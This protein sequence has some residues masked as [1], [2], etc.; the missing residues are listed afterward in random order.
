M[1]NS[2]MCLEDVI[3]HNNFK[4]LT[5]KNISYFS[6][7]RI[8]IGIM[9]DSFFSLLIPYTQMFS[10]TPGSI[11]LLSN[12]YNFG[13]LT[14][15]I[16]INVP[17]IVLSK[18]AIVYVCCFIIVIV[19]VIQALIENYYVF[20]LCRFILGNIETIIYIFGNDIYIE[21]LP[22]KNRG[23]LMAL[24]NVCMQI[25]PLII[26]FLVYFITPTFDH[27]YIK[28][29]L[30]IASVI[31]LILGILYFL[32]IT[33]GI[34]DSILN[35][36]SSKAVEILKNNNVSKDKIDAYITQVKDLQGKSGITENKSSLLDLFKNLKYRKLILATMGIKFFS[37]FLSRGLSAGIPFV[38]KKYS[39]K[40]NTVND[41]GNNALV[42]SM[43]WG[44]LISLL[45]PLLSS[46]N[47][48]PSLGRIGSMKLTAILSALISLLMIFDLNYLSILSGLTFSFMGANSLISYCY[49]SEIFPS[50][51]RSS[52]LAM[53][54][55]SSAI[56]GFLSQTVYIYLSFYSFELLVIVSV[57]VSLLDYMC[58][59]MLNKET[60][61]KALV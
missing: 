9:Y 38:I 17:L 7:V 43:I 59:L 48:Y 1:D 36:K 16:F 56:A 60:L 37:T 61:G 8:I 42:I 44:Y 52:S 12:M 26:L 14:G 13:A 51:L 25:G 39:T 21:Y 40:D 50:N 54:T 55:F 34:K 24:P 23:V 28:Y 4:L 32:F 27:H 31:P 58:C 53:M 5:I 11:A 18:K 2:I 41:S 49:V 10:L 47:D 35:G 3:D 15:S 57:V 22:V 19:F 45:K 6:V 29:V 33:D 46:I 20:L 30:L